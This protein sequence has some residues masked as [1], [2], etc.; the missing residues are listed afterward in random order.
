[1]K[2]YNDESNRLTIEITNTN[3]LPIF[4]SLA[5]QIIT[6]YNA[7]II[8]KIENFEQKYWDLLV[9]EQVLTIHSGIYMGIMI[10]FKDEENETL[11][12]SIAESLKIE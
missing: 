11:L 6:N 8:D 5:Y 2:E 3:S 12:R 1:M 9:N 7:K 10:Y 4:Q